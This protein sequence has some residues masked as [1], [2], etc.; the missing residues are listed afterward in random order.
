MFALCNELLSFFS[1]LSL[2]L[3]FSFLG[4]FYKSQNRFDLVDPLLQDCLQ[5]RIKVLGLIHPSTLQTFYTLSSIYRCIPLTRGPKAALPLLLA[6][7]E[8]HKTTGTILSPDGL[9]AMSALS[10]VY[11]SLNSIAKAEPLV[12]Y[13]IY[14]YIFLSLTNSLNRQ[15]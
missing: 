13:S 5:G 15:S 3:T 14:I 8:G 11:L 12:L 6:C 4:E 7:V 2:P 1:F 9:L 10:Q